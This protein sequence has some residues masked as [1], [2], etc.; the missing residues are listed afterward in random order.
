MP[1]VETTERHRRRIGTLVAMCMA[2]TLMSC[3]THECYWI[4]NASVATLPPLESSPVEK[5]LNIHHVVAGT[6]MVIAMRDEYARPESQGQ[7]D[8]QRFRKITV[9][10]PMAVG[11]LDL[12]DPKVNFRYSEG[13]VAFASGGRGVYAIRAGD[14]IA[15]AVDTERRPT[16]VTVHGTLPVERTDASGSGSII[17]DERY[18]CSDLSVHEVTPWIGQHADDA[19]A[20]VSPSATWNHLVG[21]L[22][23]KQ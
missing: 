15:V 21:L 14:A 20:E 18:E 11:S 13:N 1:I 6:G 5:L 10:T 22:V 9:G 16:L 7:S 8:V 17:L 4:A 12:H 2:A 19:Y 3:K 23:G